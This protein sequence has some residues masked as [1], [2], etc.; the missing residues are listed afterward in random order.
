MNWIRSLFRLSTQTQIMQYYTLW[1]ALQEVVLQPTQDTITWRWT[2]SG[3][4]TAASAYKCQ[5]LGSC[6]PFSTTKIWSAH[7]E[8]SEERRV[9]KECLL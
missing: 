6:T 7:V 8:R 5:F 2:A 9:G 3:Q 4:Y 1:S